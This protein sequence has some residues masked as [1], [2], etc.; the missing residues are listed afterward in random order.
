VPDYH[1]L[2]EGLELAALFQQLELLDAAALYWQLGGLE[3]EQE[4]F[5]GENELPKRLGAVV[6]MFAYIFVTRLD[7][8]RQF[9]TEARINAEQLVNCVPGH[10][11]VVRTEEAAR[12][13]AF[14]VE[15]AI[16]W[17]K[18]RDHEAVEVLTVESVVASLWSFVSSRANLWE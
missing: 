8:W 2:A 4:A 12:M 5:E 1:G 11:T 14:T 17:M 16:I 6:K 10:D 3:A 9:C 13:M 15:E 18:E 7:G